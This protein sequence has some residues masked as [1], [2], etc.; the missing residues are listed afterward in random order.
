MSAHESRNDHALVEG[1]HDLAAGARRNEKGADDGGDD[2][3]C[4]EGERVNHR[5]ER[6]IGTVVRVQ[7]A[8]EQHGRDHGD[9]VGLEEISRHAGTVADVVADVVGDDR[10]VARVVLGDAR[11]DLADQ[12][13]A[14]IGALGEDAA[15]EAREDR[16]QR[17]AEGE[18]H[19]RVQRPFVAERRAQQRE[20]A[21]DPDHREADHQ[22]ARDGAA[23]ERHAE[24]GVEPGGSGLRGTH[25]GAHR[26]IHADVTGEPREQRADREA[27]GGRPAEPGEADD[28]EEH[29]ADDEDGAVLAVEVSLGT[30]LYGGGDLLHA[31][32][33]GRQAQDGGHRKHAVQYGEH[34][35]RDRGPQPL[36]GIHQEISPGKKGRAL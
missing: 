9:G 35:G 7:Q 21:G 4:T 15:A 5:R 25:V 3:G 8:S 10:G 20:V 24:R 22:H 36:G 12:V 31:R 32:A 26:D 14:D 16:D 29:D 11:F 18:A 27:A 13:G 2:G 28:Q 19:Q 30:R 34:P 1:G 33:A 6:G 17:A 23:P